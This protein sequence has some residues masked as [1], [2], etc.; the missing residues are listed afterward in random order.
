VDVRKRA[1][2]R[3]KS[4]SWDNTDLFKLEILSLQPFVLFDIILRRL[5]LSIGWLVWRGRELLG[6]ELRGGHHDV[7]VGRW[8]H[9]S[10]TGRR[11]P[12]AHGER[13]LLDRRGRK[14]REGQPRGD[15]LMVGEEA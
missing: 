15:E 3:G 13:G 11:G 12:D 6:V 2:R 8:S 10:V 1:D 4:P 5:L 9:W 7:S 14:G